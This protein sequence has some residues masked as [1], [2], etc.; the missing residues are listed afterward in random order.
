MSLRFPLPSW[1]SRII[2]AFRGVL[3]VIDWK[4]SEKP[5]PFLSNTYDNPVQV[6]AYA[7][8]LND[9]ANYKYQVIRVP[10]SPMF[11]L[12]TFAFNLQFKSIRGAMSHAFITM[13]NKHVLVVR[14]KMGSLLW[15]TRTAPRPTLT[16]SA[17]TWCQSTGRRGCCALKNTRNKGEADR[18][19]GS[20]SVLKKVYNLVLSRN[21]KKENSVV[22]HYFRDVDT[23][24]VPNHWV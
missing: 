21:M 10:S 11:N 4:T 18:K 13:S 16:S 8:A 2:S 20:C 9:D 19:Q 24:F 5:K 6:A 14:L 22:K 17:Q 12:S 7:G 1:Y 23:M 3:C 15:P